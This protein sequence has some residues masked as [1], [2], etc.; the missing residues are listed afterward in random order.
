MLVSFGVKFYTNRLIVQ[1]NCFLVPAIF[2]RFL[3]SMVDFPLLSFFN[4]ARG[5]IF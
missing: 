3:I 5:N 1:V 2:V 4:A